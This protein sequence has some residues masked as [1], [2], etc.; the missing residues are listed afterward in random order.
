MIAPL[1]M[2][3]LEQAAGAA[4]KSAVRAAPELLAALE[5]HDWP[6]NV[7]ELKAV[8]ERALL[9]ARGGELGTRHLVFAKPEPT[10]GEPA[11]LPPTAAPAGGEDLS[12]LDPAQIEE[13]AK[14]IAVLDACAGN[15]TRAAKMLGVSRSTLVNKLVLF[16]IPRPRQ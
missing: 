11:P 10:S 14:I 1:A 4:G 6:G 8:I 12:F 5:A 16:R 13:R 7:R 2:R 9:L 3:F 15:Q